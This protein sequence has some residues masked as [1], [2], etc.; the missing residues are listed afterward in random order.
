MWFLIAYIA[1]CC[2]ASTP[3]LAQTRKPVAYPA[4]QQ[5]F[6]GEQHLHTTASV[7]SDGV[8]ICR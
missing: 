7:S 3:A 5:V 2:I 6:F 1:A 8:H 4:K